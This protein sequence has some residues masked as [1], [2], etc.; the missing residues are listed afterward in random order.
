M[1]I[2]DASEIFKDYPATHIHG[3]FYSTLNLHESAFHEYF[4]DKP[5]E[6]R[7]SGQ[8]LACCFQMTKALAKSM[9]A[10]RDPET[11]VK[12]RAYIDR[13]ENLKKR[14]Y[15]KKMLMTP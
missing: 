7:P 13:L 15:T 6:L 14:V 11:N 5:C 1:S 4:I 2:K 12:L 10:Y 8:R 3:E 9:E